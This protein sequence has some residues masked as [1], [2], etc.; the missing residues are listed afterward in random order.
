MPILDQKNI[1]ANE[2]TGVYFVKIST[3]IIHTSTKFQ[4]IEYYE[5]NKQV[6]YRKSQIWM[7]SRRF[8]RLNVFTC[9]DP[10]IIPISFSSNENVESNPE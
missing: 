8:V 4:Y 5:I 7:E 10:N 1:W 2:F 9:P 6:T 3:N